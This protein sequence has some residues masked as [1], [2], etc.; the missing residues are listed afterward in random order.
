VPGTK[1]VLVA[2]NDV[3]IPGWR[4]MVVPSKVTASFSTNPADG[5]KAGTLTVGHVGKA[6]LVVRTH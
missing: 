1:T 6:T 4:G 5:A 3:T 2:A